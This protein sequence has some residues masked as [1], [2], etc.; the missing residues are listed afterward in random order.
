MSM[1]VFLHDARNGREGWANLVCLGSCFKV[2]TQTKVML[3]T[4]AD[5][6]F[7]VFIQ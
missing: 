7:D 4:I 5:T 2:Q 1:I 6:T 3:P